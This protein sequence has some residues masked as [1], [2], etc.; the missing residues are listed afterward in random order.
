MEQTKQ[1][2]RDAERTLHSGIGV[3]HLN[4]YGRFDKISSK[5]KIDLDSGALSQRYSLFEEATL[6]YQL[7]PRLKI[8]LG[9]GMIPFHRKHWGVLKHSYRDS[10]SELNPEHS[11]RDQDR[12]ILL[13]FIYGGYR[14]GLINTFTIWGNS[15]RPGFDDNGELEFTGRGKSLRLAYD[16]RVTFNTSDEQGIAN[17]FEL[18]F[19][20][21]HSLYLSGIAYNSDWNPH[22]SYALNTAYGYRDSK[23]EVWFEYTYGVFGTHWGA[24]YAVQKNKEHLIQLGAD[25]YLNSLFNV[26]A[27]VEYAKVDKQNHSN[28]QGNSWYNDGLLHDVDTFKVETGIKYKFPGRSGHLTFGLFYEQKNKVSGGV[29]Q[30]T[31]SALQVANTISFWF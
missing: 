5:I 6:T 4:L 11:W 17:K 24:K 31:L 28:E 29:E 15:S 21:S 16:T 3:L 2:N 7:F 30:P 14:S 25:R 1:E 23:W 22:W 8:R 18:F 27:N 13:S 10:G 19:K 26:L 20:R 9:K 12:K